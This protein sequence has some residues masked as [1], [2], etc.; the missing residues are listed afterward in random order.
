M[1]SLIDAT[2][3]RSRRT[4][5]LRRHFLRCVELDSGLVLRLLGKLLL[6]E[7]CPFK[8]EDYERAWIVFSSTSSSHRF[9][10]NEF[11]FNSFPVV[12]DYIEIG[13]VSE[14]FDR[15]T[16]EYRLEVIFENVQ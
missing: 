8:I 7:T 13:G 11:A 9:K 3:D 16:I 2:V 15:W 12:D 6:E 4:V 1:A 10:L 14:R 5:L